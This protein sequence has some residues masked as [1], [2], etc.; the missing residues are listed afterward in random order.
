MDGGPPHWEDLLGL[1]SPQ[2]V[3][4]AGILNPK[5]YPIGGSCFLCLLYGKTAREVWEPEDLLNTDRGAA[6]LT[7]PT[8]FFPFLSGRQGEQP[9]PPHPL[10]LGSPLPGTGPTEDAQ[11]RPGPLLIPISIRTRGS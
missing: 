1:A 3:H 5:S 9:L 2:Q 8:P 11:T 6:H 4:Q 7:D 10:L